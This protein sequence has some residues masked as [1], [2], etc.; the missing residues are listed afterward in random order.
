MQN[1]KTKNFIVTTIITI[2][3]FV[4]LGPA[5][6]AFGRPSNDLDSRL[7]RIENLLRNQLNVDNLNKIEVLQ[8]ELQDL[9]G[10]V[11]EQSYQL[12]LLAKKQFN[13]CNAFNK[14]KAISDQEQQTDNNSFEDQR[15][16]VDQ[17]S[18]SISDININNSDNYPENNDQE[19]LGDEIIIDDSA[20]LTENDKYNQAYSALLDNQASEA[21]VFFANFLW[22]FPQSKH[23][24]DVYFWLGE[25]NLTKWEEDKSNNIALESAIQNF[26]K[27]VS[28]HYEHDKAKDAMLKL[29]LIA[30]QKS[31][32]KN[33]K[34]Y[35]EK[36]IN[37]FPN[38][39]SASIARGK[40]RRF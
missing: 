40:L 23:V 11:E 31:E 4:Y 15:E 29:A 12:K 7:S 38:T 14:N 1:N 28:L 21:A 35:Y 9:R 24:P 32:L 17:N 18:K 37:D 19:S 5:Q 25:I 2:I 27:I 39:S 22:E 6:A 26:D 13:S 34:N 36:I 20:S 10:Q 3:G 33:A 30:E 16:N 8:Q